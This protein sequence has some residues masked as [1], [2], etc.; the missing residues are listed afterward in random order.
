MEIS[1]RTGVGI[2]LGIIFGIPLI[3]LL[4]WKAKGRGIRKAAAW[5]LAVV[6]GFAGLFGFWW[7]IGAFYP[8]PSLGVLR[9]TAWK[10]IL[11]GI[12]LSLPFLAM[13]LGACYLALR[14]ATMALRKEKAAERV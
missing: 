14:F 2:L 10:E 4:A 13:P 5:V 9:A 1:E 3:Y 12:V 8:F 6:S 11:M 7:M